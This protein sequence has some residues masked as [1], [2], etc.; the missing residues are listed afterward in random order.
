MPKLRFSSIQI[1]SPVKT[2]SVW[3]EIFYAGLVLLAEFVQIF[4]FGI[5]A[6]SRMK[7]E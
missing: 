4:P 3:A 1:C 2:L 6:V 5:T 7:M